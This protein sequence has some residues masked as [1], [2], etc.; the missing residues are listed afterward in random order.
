MPLFGSLFTAIS[1]MNAQSRALSNISG[2]VANSQTVGFKR[3]DTSF[4]D[5]VAQS[6]VNGDASGAVSASSTA[7]TDIQGAVEQVDNPLSLA[8]G[9]RGFF[10]VARP[11]SRAADGTASFD[12]QTMV[13]RAGDFSL[14][15]DGYLVNGTGYA[16]QGWASRADGTLDRNTL[17]P[18]RISTSAYQPVPTSQLS[19][20]ANLP[21]TPPDGAMTSTVQVY[22]QL[23][24]QQS[25][26]MSWTQ[27][28]TDV[29]TLTVTP[30]TSTEAIGSIDL[31]FG[32]TASGTTA[33]AGTLGGF[34]NGNGLAGSS[35]AQGSPA[36]VSFNADFGQGQQ[37]ITLNL[38]TFGTASGITQYGGS[39][40]EMRTLSQ[41]GAAPGAFSSVSIKDNGEVVVNYDNG[42]NTVM[43]KV[44]VVT[45]ADPDKL[46]R[47]DGQAFTETAEAG[48]ALVSDAG[49][50]GTGQLDVGSVERSNVDISA[51]F[52][53]LI[54]AQRAY[55]ANTK[56]VTATDEMLQD[57]LN[58][59]R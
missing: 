35:F 3:L 58:M 33:A 4:D 26:Q 36:T 8:L 10:S 57:A 46:G 27:K 19:M 31:N 16:L 50:N 21:A 6:G 18:L 53:K 56:I 45:Y 43:G 54:V 1:G 7:T 29:W 40:Y 2:N 12:P 15:R 17:V 59:R 30:G 49:S 41:D 22:D 44:P 14:D 34:A 47:L 28:S 39:S 11:V 51:E 9:G 32:P 13:S 20:S 52:S 48:S 25:L 23:G 38:G 37:P 5:L 55:S 24:N 42:R